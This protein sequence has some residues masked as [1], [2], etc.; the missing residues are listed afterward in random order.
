MPARRWG[1]QSF[2]EMFGEITDVAV[3]IGTDVSKIVEWQETK[4]ADL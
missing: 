4:P 1:E 3:D 2:S